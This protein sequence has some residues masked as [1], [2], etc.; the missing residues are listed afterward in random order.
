MSYHSMEKWR[1]IYKLIKLLTFLI[2]TILYTS[3]SNYK[4]MPTRRQFI[5]GTALTTLGLGAGATLTETETGKNA[6]K[7]ISILA[8]SE[9]PGSL[10]NI[11]AET[12]EEILRSMHKVANHPRPDTKGKMEEDA[13]NNLYDFLGEKTTKESK[14]NPLSS[15][16]GRTFE[17]DGVQY[18]IG[19]DIINGEPRVSLSWTSEKNSKKGKKIEGKWYF[20]LGV[21]GQLRFADTH[22]SERIIKKEEFVNLLK[23]LDY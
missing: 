16:R 13:F 8:H 5:I 18:G 19:I 10:E 4:I 20:R 15:K 7:V 22:K 12:P 6:K 23:K 21:D 11:A 14:Y 17:I 3:I 9:E 1:I 2:K